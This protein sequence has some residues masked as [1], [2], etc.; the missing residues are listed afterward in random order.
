LKER[1]TRIPPTIEFAGV[2]RESYEYHEKVDGQNSRLGQDFRR[3]IYSFQG[4]AMISPVGEI[5]A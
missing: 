3:I 5:T 4:Q 2:L 1:W